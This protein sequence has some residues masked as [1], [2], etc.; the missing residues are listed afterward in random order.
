MLVTVGVALVVADLCLAAFGGNPR[1]IQPPPPVS[2]AF[3]LGPVTY[4]AYRLF[5]IG[6]AVARR[7][8]ALPRP[9]PLEA[10][11]AHP[12]RRR[13]PRD[14]PSAM[15]IDID[16][17]FTI[18]FVV[19][20]GLAGL[21]GVAAAGALTIRPGADTDILLFA[22][23][24]VIVGGL[25]SVAGRGHRQRPHRRPRRVREGVDPRALLLRG[26]PADGDRA[27]AAAPWAARP[28]G[29]S[30][31]RT[32]RAAAVVLACVA[33]VAAPL[34]LSSYLLTLLT[35]VFIAGLLAASVNFLAGEAG[36]VSMGQAG[37]AAAAAYGVAYATV[38]GHDVVIQVGLALV[39]AARRERRLRRHD[40]AQPR[41]RL[42][43]DHARAR[44]DGLRA[45]L[46]ARERHRW[47]ERA[48]RHRPARAHRRELALLPR[49]RGGL[50]HRD[51]RCCATCRAR[52]SASRSA[53]CARARAG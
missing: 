44:H 34:V 45:R 22:L 20:A 21:A 16:R 12:R 11:R 23:V 13:R 5:L 25:G 50:R 38:R 3:D 26:L 30:R 8:R 33:V 10:R 14:R 42:P 52:P 48:D 15:G 39:V 17:L 51:A 6:L 41:H 4:P 9:A 35:L 53:A 29:V 49:L 43:D 24:V 1:S 40:D 37:I 27:R 36:L 47:P 19:G 32:V 18:M 2:G 46:Q 31:S 7:R 28:P